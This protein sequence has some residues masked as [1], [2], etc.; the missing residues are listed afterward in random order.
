MELKVVKIFFLMILKCER[1]TLRRGNS[2]PK[3]LSLHESKLIE[4]AISR[5]MRLFY[6][7]GYCE[8]SKVAGFQEEINEG[9]K[10]KLKLFK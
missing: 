3:F 10:L 6:N 7:G 8:S 2:D 1:I 9:V 5:S 4:D